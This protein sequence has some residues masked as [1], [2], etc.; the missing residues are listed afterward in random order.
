MS[1]T[2]PLSH[3]V[4]AWLFA[5]LPSAGTEN[6]TAR[7]Q[8]APAVTKCFINRSHAR[9]YLLLRELLCISVFSA[10]LLKPPR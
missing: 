4:C 10:L 3:V 9:G 1:S 2:C 6:T 8:G 5:P 7:H